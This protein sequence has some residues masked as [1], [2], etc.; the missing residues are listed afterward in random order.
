LILNRRKLFWAL[1]IFSLACFLIAHTKAS[2][3]RK[4]CEISFYL[5]AMHRYGNSPIFRYRAIINRR[6]WR[7]DILPIP[8]FCHFAKFKDDIMTTLILLNLIQLICF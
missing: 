6:Y 4:T 1:I 2:G 7:T 5:L 3:R 8:I